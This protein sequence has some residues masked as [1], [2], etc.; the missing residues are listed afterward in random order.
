M[1]HHA[2]CSSCRDQHIDQ[3]I[4]PT[5]FCLRCHATLVRVV[6]LQ[7]AA[8]AGLFRAMS[9]RRMLCRARRLCMTHFLMLRRVSLLRTRRFRPALFYARLLRTWRFHPV[10]F[11]ARLFSS[12]RFYRP[13]LFSARLFHTMRFHLALFSARLLR[14]MRFRSALFYARLFQ[15][16]LRRP[17]SLLARRF[18]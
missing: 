9:F 8:P 12:S 15:P 3:V 16:S 11:F 18:V 14:S 13:V 6:D 2:A 4:A 1:S 5:A 10:L 17:R 7:R